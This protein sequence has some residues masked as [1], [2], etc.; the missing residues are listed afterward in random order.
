MESRRSKTTLISAFRPRST[1]ETS[2]LRYRLERTHRRRQTDQPDASDHENDPDAHSIITPSKH[3]PRTWRILKGSVATGG[4]LRPFR[5][6]KQDILNLR[7]RYISDWAFFN[8]QILASAIF[9][10]FT[11]LLPGITFASDLFVLTGANWGTIEVVLSTGLCGII[12]SLTSIQPLTIL[13]VTGP[14][15]VLGE[16]IYSLTQDSFKVPGFFLAP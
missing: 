10:F 1:R 6:L 8:Q 12:F 16:T 3:T 11:N 14:F 5:L 7:R 9:V 2:S 4:P 15:S 13:G